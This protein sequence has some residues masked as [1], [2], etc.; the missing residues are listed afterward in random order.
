MPFKMGINFRHSNSV[1]FY[2]KNAKETLMTWLSWNAITETK[3]FVSGKNFVW[4]TLPL[5]PPP[6]NPYLNPWALLSLL[7]K[8]VKIST[9]MTS[10]SSG[11]EQFSR[12]GWLSLTFFCKKEHL[13]WEWNGCQPSWHEQEWMNAMSWGI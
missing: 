7:W 13:Y 3:T 5:I 10:P 6:L 1:I 12:T 11:S 8:L 4:W 9:F 2:A